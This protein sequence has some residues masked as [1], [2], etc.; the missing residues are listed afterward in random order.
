MAKT[1]ESKVVVEAKAPTNE[2]QVEAQVDAT[3][4]AEV[5]NQDKI[6][7]LMK[8]TDEMA[9]MILLGNDH[10]PAESKMNVATVAAYKLAL[11][12][13]GLQHKHSK[14]C[15]KV[16]ESWVKNKQVLEMVD[17]VQKGIKAY[18][19][20]DKF[21]SI[22]T[23]DICASQYTI[24]CGTNKV[25]R[26][27]TKSST[28][29]GNSGQYDITVGDAKFTS[30]SAVLKS[31]NAQPNGNSAYRVCL[32]YF[33]PTV[34]TWKDTDEN[35]KLIHNTLKGDKAISYNLVRNGVELKDKHEA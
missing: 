21:H 8:L 12:N 34:G 3:P 19:E 22:I 28:S 23:I 15:E 4:V 33:N 30:W 5:V 35:G 27:G 10:A 1:A 7:M 2:V 17:A 29:D 16:T 32:M 11:A 20:D 31:I 14:Y 18:T 6:T 24:H 25:K 13:R 26:T 9:E